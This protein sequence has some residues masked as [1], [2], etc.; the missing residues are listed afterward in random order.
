MYSINDWRLN[1]MTKITHS[2]QSQRPIGNANQRM[3]AHEPLNTYISEVGS[4][5][6]E[7]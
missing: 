5:A 2:N 4:V 1:E 3:G 6:M 7:E